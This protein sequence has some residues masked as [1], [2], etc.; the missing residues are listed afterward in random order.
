MYT[1]WVLI[2]AIHVEAPECTHS[3]CDM[4]AHIRGVN[5]PLSLFCLHPA[6]FCY[7]PSLV[8][9]HVDWGSGLLTNALIFSQQAR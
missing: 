7:M 9:P 8:I 1:D 4:Y 3:T 2:P 5:L 6:H